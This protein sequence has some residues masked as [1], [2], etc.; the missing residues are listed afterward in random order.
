M[1]DLFSS[2]NYPFTTDPWAAQEHEQ[3]TVDTCKT[4]HECVY[5]FIFMPSKC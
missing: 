4:S 3:S 1:R 5:S 2:F